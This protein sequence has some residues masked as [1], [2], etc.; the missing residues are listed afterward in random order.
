MSEAPPGTLPSPTLN[1]SDTNP[2]DRFHHIMMEDEQAFAL[3]DYRKLMTADLSNFDNERFKNW[4]LQ[5][6]GINLKLHWAQELLKVI[7]T[8]M[9]HPKRVRSY[10][11]K[12]RAMSIFGRTI[13]WPHLLEDQNLKPDE[14]EKLI[15]RCLR[16]ITLY[17]FIFRDKIHRV[18]D[19]RRGEAVVQSPPI[20]HFYDMSMFSACTKAQISCSHLIPDHYAAFTLALKWKGEDVLIAEDELQ[21]M[22]GNHELLNTS[23]SSSLLY[24]TP[25]A[26]LLAIFFTWQE[27]SPIMRGTFYSETIWW[28]NQ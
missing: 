17:Y 22:D 5:E 9:L 19:W 14:E 11:E 13:L 4:I 8:C 18:I 26:E 6:S 1:E 10:R 3:L 16:I 20:Q 7:H 23:C 27:V 25:A 24:D 21:L 28:F 15:E 12:Y 2:F